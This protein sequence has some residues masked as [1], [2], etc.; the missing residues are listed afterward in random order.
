MLAQP[1]AAAGAELGDLFEYKLSDR[2]T[3]RRNQSALV[4]ILQTGV[5]ADRLSLW[6]EAMGLRPRRAVWLRNTSPLALDAG[7][8]SIV[9]GG[10]FAGEGL[11]DALKPNERRLVTYAADLGVQVNV[12]A[13]RAPTRVVRLRAAK[14]VVTQES[15]QRSR[16]TYSVRND[17]RDARTVVL[18]HPI[19]AD[20]TLAGNAKPEEST[21]AVH[22]FRVSVPAGQAIALDVDEV[23]PGATTFQVTELH[24]ERLQML[25][26]S[27]ESR[28]QV[29]RAMAPLFAKSAEI[30]EIESELERVN[31]DLQQIGQD[32]ERVRENIKALRDSSV[33]RRLL[34]RYTRQLE[35]QENRV[36]TLKKAQAEFQARQA[37]AERELNDLIAA[38]TFDVAP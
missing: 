27:G 38:L 34:E 10:A 7:S 4:P 19:R 16:R 25:V 15:E 3:I 22:R 1:I 11:I 31:G 37:R 29:E 26:T 23:R 20:W 12:R 14:G 33:E 2:V 32:Q 24:H 30:E 5:A 17:D 35:E 13:D 36:D 8:L 28:Q 18:E 21:A 6:N 9:D